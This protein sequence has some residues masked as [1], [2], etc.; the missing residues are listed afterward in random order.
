V[1]DFLFDHLALAIEEGATAR[2]N[3]GSGIQCA[4]WIG[5]GR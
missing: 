3:A 2:R 5:V 4:L 1:L